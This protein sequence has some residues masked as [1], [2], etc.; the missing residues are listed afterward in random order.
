M[1]ILS[2]VFA[3][4]QTITTIWEKSVLYGNYPDGQK[5]WANGTEMNK[6]MGRG[7]NFGN[8]FENS[9][10]PEGG[11]VIPA[12]W[13][14]DVADL[15][16]K[17]VR[18]PVQ[19]SRTDRTLIEAPYTIDTEFMNTIKTTVDECLKNKLNV[20]VNIHHYRELMADPAGHRQRY[21]A[22]WRQISEVFKE[23][24]D[25]VMF[26][27]IS[28]PNDKMTSEIWNDFYA[29]VRPLIR[30]TNPKRVIWLGTPDTGGLSAIEELYIPDDPYQIL[31]IHAYAPFR[32]THQGAEWVSGANNWMGTTW[33]DSQYERDQITDKFDVALKISKEKNIPINIGEFGAYYTA[34]MEHR[35]KW[36]RFNARWFEMQNFSW[37]YW[38]YYAG[39]GIYDE[40]TGLYRQELVDALLNDPMPE[41]APTTLKN[42]YTSNFSAGND[43][44]YVENASPANSS[45]TRTNGILQVNISS[46]GDKEWKIKLYRRAAVLER[47]KV[48]NLTFKARSVEPRNISVSI[49]D[50]STQYSYGD[51][52]YVDN[53]E[54][55][56][57]LS[58]MS[59]ENS[60]SVLTTTINITLGNTGTSNFYLQNVKFN[61]VVFE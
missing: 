44:W 19:W 61:E 4:S 22:I 12:K 20:V 29:E 46:P 48:Y 8:V 51:K 3:F 14:K 15:G 33:N 53:T 56:Y 34:K 55:E 59:N 10:G 25:S 2:S 30:E 23:Y 52:F 58:F 18:I 45:L 9:I 50:L 43:N 28:E 6:R 57:R 11:R 32:F 16:F 31:S 49:A 35:V 37:T 38:D 42:L 17:H 7:V 1:M 54:K 27:P 39:M 13:I 47:R 41:P 5:T 24:P 36:T 60:S 40:K 21:M 26:E